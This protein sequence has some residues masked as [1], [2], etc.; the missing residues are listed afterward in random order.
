MHKP[1]LCQQIAL[2]DGFGGDYKW[3]REDFAKLEKYF[4]CFG[5]V[6]ATAQ[7]RLAFTTAR[8]APVPAA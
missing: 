2:I 3:I 4:E 5:Q 8:A 7:R 6:H 1:F